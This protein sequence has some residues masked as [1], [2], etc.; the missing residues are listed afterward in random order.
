MSFTRVKIKLFNN[1][2]TRKYRKILIQT[3][4]N[5]KTVDSSLS[6]FF[7]MTPSVSCI[8]AAYRAKFQGNSV[9]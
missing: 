7:L 9:F 4:Y 5:L 2:N 6:F 1:D 8:V 3:F